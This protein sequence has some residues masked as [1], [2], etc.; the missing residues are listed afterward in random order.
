VALSALV[1]GCPGTDTSAGNSR[2]NFESF[3]PR[4]HVALKAAAD[5]LSNYDEGTVH[6]FEGDLI[7]DKATDDGPV[8]APHHR[9]SITRY[10]EAGRHVGSGPTKQTEWTKYR[11]R[12]SI[13][14]KPQQAAPGWT[15]VSATFE[16]TREAKPLSLYTDL[17]GRTS[18]AVAEIPQRL[19]LI[20]LALSRLA[21]SQGPAPEAGAVSR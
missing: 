11:G 17:G 12:Q 18:E 21:E 19:E 14:L 9:V 7:I 1:A 3:A 10:F 13:V 20:E 6:G 2:S 8:A 5:T 4:L 15:V 16:G